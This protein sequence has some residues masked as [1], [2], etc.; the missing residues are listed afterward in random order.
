M[1]ALHV[2]GEDLEK[3]RIELE[4]RLSEITGENYETERIKLREQILREQGKALKQNGE[5]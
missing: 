4:E 1:E 2:R 3:R 5:N